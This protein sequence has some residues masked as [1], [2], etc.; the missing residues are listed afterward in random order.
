LHIH[1]NEIIAKIQRRNTRPLTLILDSLWHK[2]IAIV[3]SISSKGFEG[4]RLKLLRSG[5]ESSSEELDVN[6]VDATVGT[7]IVE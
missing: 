2:E 5:E 4:K 3:L 7:L 1:A 6:G